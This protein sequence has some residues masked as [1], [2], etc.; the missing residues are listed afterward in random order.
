MQGRMALRGMR[1]HVRI[2]GNALEMA[3][4]AALR[5]RGYQTIKNGRFVLGLR[6]ILSPIYRF[7]T[8]SSK[9][10]SALA[11]TVLAAKSTASREV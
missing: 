11:T 8:A 2:A 9:F 4:R 1:Q 5:G 3:E 6:P 7:V 10:I